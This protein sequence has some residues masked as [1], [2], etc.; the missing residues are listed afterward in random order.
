MKV[1]KFD[2]ATGRRGEQIADWRRASWTDARWNEYD[3]H[4]PVGFGRD[5]EVTVHHNAGITD[6]TGANDISYRRP[7]EWICFCLGC[8]RVGVH[9]D[10]TPDEHWEWI[11]LPPTRIETRA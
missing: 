3:G 4:A 10:G 2:P 9:D 7:T 5:A 11:V 1:F 6:A 8:W